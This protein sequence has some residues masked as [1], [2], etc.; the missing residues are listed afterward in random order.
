VFGI[1]QEFDDIV[2][3]PIEFARDLLDQPKEVSSLEL[4]YKKAPILTSAQ[5]KITDAIGK[6]FTV[7]NRKQQNTEL[8]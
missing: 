2:V 6:N 5:N 3:T 1:Q 7:K 4:I 8:V